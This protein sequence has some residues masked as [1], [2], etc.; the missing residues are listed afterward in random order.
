MNGPGVPLVAIEAEQSVIGAVLL[1]NGALDRIC[2]SLVAEHFSRDDHRRIWRAIQRLRGE[3]KPADVVTVFA[4]MEASGEA[5]QSGG[6]AY[7]G[8]IAAATYSAANVRRYAEIVVERAV[9]RS[10]AAASEEIASLVAD[11]SLSLTEKLQAAQGLVM[12]VADAGALRRTDPQ[13]LKDALTRHCDVLEARHEGRVA[14][15]PTGFDGLDRLL[16]GGLRAGQLIIVAGRPGMG[17]TSLAAQMGHHAAATGEPTLFLSQEMTEADITDRLLAATHGIALSSLVS[18]Q[19]S[20][21]GWRRVT[22]ALGALNE[23]PL[24]LD[25]QPALTLLD[26]ATKARKVQRS[27]GLGLLVI[28]YLQL[29]TGTGDNRNAEL[30][31][32]SRGLKQLAKEL[33]IPVIALSQLSRECEKRPNKRPMTSDL[34]DSGSLEQDADVILAIYRDDIYNP[35]SPDG[36]TAEVLVRKNRQGRIGD[37]R[38]AWRGE[39]AAFGNLDTEA[40]AIQRRQEVE[41]KAL[42]RPMARHRRGGFDD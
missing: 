29:M 15:L 27:A 32:I 3:S 41:R 14:G 7:L 25:D 1:D 16:N 18:G 33:S 35:D 22:A 37:V 11:P 34:R 36:G 10:L 4:A 42:E 2:V 26:V 40:W 20:D 5:E 30:E 9:L 24:Y 12:T 28:D 23:L 17:K 6:L 21:D 8:E 31:R 19:L 13:C 39:C 38:L